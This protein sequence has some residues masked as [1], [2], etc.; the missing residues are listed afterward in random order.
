MTDS[1]IVKQS[2]NGKQIEKN[3]NIKIEKKDITKV[4]WRSLFG[5]QIGWNYEKMQG[6]GYCFALMP[7]LK[8]LYKN[9]E[10][11]KKALKLHLQFFNTTP[12]SVSLSVLTIEKA[13]T[14][15]KEGK[16]DNDKVFVIF[17][18]P[19]DCIRLIEKGI[20]IPVLNVGNMS[21][22]SG[23]TSVKKSVNV[24]KEDVAAF[25]MLDSMGVKIT[26]RMIPNEPE[27][28]FMNL[29]KGL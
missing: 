21:T 3:G 23:T 4:F 10:D 9:K 26:A 16:Y 19:T 28:N 25:K 18:N 7:I 6:L 12:P 27:T 13:A 20:E 17:K 5:L 11:M 14:R 22:K 15:I 24:S 1:K 29:I 8:K 2:E